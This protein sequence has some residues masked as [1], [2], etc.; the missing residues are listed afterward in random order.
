MNS[1]LDDGFLSEQP[2]RHL[3]LDPD[4]VEEL[5]QRLHEDHPLLGTLYIINHASWPYM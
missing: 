5:Y 3:A 4:M 1:I 2:A